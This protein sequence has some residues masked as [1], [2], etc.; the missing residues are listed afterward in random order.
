MLDDLFGDP[1]EDA[2]G[3]V[4]DLIF[5]DFFFLFFVNH[6]LLM[7]IRLLL[8]KILVVLFQLLMRGSIFFIVHC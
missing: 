3:H 8:L 5:V 7:F 4:N 1:D 2:L 6:F